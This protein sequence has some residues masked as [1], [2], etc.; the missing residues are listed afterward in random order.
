MPHAPQ[1]STVESEASFDATGHCHPE[2]SNMLGMSRFLSA[3]FY[4]HP[5][6]DILLGFG[7]LK[8]FE[9]QR[10]NTVNPVSTI[11]YEYKPILT[12]RHL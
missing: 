7:S 1:I 9:G 2:S 6:I 8:Q 12:Q 3:G 10:K 5:L 11:P 4:M